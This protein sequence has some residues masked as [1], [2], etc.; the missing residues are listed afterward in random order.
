MVMFSVTRSKTKLLYTLHKIAVLISGISM[1]CAGILWSTFAISAA[2]PPFTLKSDQLL[3]FDAGTGSVLYSRGANETFP[4]ASLAK[5][6]T[7]EIVFHALKNGTLQADDVFSVSEHAWR[8]G[9]APSGTS[10]MFAKIKSQITVHDLLQGL[11]VQTANDAAIVLAE[12]ISG[13]EQA[14]AKLMNERAQA[15]GLLDSVFV[16]P[17]GLPQEGTP[18]EV[19]LR[20]MVKLARHLHQAYPNYYPLYAQESFKW[21]NIYQRNR[22]P[23]LRLDIGA[24]GLGMGGTAAT[25]Y[26]FI[27]SAKQNERRVFL[28]ING[29]KTAQD[30]AEDAEKL[31]RWAMDDFVRMPVFYNNTEVA[32]ASLY[33]GEQ[34][35]VGL[36][37]HE[38]ISV[39]LPRNNKGKLR[40]QVIYKGPVAAPVKQGQEIGRL[41]VFND[42]DLLIERPVFAAESV[43]EGSLREKALGALYELATGWIRRLL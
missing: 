22:N 43:A 39:L 33:G 34:G 2:E 5:L 17:T 8:T 32:Q 25:G 10:T 14:F 13:S 11:I 40:S 6:M 27:A 3:L 4:P 20:D 42:N 19:S 30:R 28:G 31:I 37:V 35:S 38:N 23:L 7:A 12:G 9:G 16:N 24:D 26:S 41:Q 29:A 1:F 21:N 15:L 18:Q 36:V